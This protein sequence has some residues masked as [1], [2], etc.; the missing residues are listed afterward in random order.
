MIILLV[1]NTYFSI[2]LKGADDPLQFKINLVLNVKI[3]LPVLFICVAAGWS[4]FVF[5]THV[6]DTC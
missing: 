4:C 5:K 6:V 2:I 1:K 3:A